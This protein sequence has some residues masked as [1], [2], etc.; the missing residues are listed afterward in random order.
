[1]LRK[2]LAAVAVSALLVTL[3]CRSAPLYNVDSA[4]VSA[5]KPVTLQDVERAITRHTRIIAINFPHNPTGS[6]IDENTLRRLAALAADAGV[7]LFSDEV[8]RGMEYL[9]GDLLPAAADLSDTAVSLGVLSKSYALAGLRIGWLRRSPRPAPTALAPAPPARPVG[10]HWRDSL[11]TGKRNDAI[12]L[13]VP[14]AGPGANRWRRRHR[15]AGPSGAWHRS[16]S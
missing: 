13:R 1:M 11:R 4:P 16:C 2:A 6:H 5:P 14:P 7:T 10:R 9:P 12:Q 15:F 8:Y 3:G